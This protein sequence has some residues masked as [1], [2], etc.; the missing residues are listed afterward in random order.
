MRE[1]VLDT[2]TTG[3]DPVAGHR[4][5]EIACIELINSVPSGAFFHRYVNPE[6]DIPAEAYAVHK[7]SLEFLGTKP[8]FAEIVDEF[9]AFLGDSPLIA[10]NAEFDCK[11]VNAELERCGRPK[12]SCQI[13]DTVTMARQKFPGSAVSLDALCKRFNV[14][15][16]ARTVHGARLDAE[17][18]AVVYLELQGGRQHGLGLAAS[19]DL[20]SGSPLLVVPGRDTR[21][22]PPRPHEPTADELAAHAAFLTKLKEPLW[23]A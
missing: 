22:R 14:D 12:V 15:N 17:L 19:A 23:S 6:R 8:L 13:I 11:F 20:V 10:H 9:L 7:L 5:V 4:L 3:L 21:A 16:S 2:E 18:L 1:I